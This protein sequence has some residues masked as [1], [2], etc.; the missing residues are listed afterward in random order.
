MY[1]DKYTYTYSS[2]NHADSMT[3]PYSFLPPAFIIICS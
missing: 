1:I 2:S 3:F